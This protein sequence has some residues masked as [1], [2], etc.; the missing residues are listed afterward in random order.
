MR[1]L[2]ARSR[3]IERRKAERRPGK[4]HESPAWIREKRFQ[5]VPAGV[6]VHHRPDRQQNDSHE[7]RDAKA[8]LER[9]DVDGEEGRSYQ[10]LIRPVASRN[11]HRMAMGAE[12]RRQFV[13]RKGTAKIAFS[14]LDGRVQVL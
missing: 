4:D 3:P 12:K 8:S 9:E 7:Q 10:L 6:A 5:Q 13:L 2:H 14:I 11:H 1:Q